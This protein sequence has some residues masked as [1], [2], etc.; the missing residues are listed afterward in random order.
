MDIEK[1]EWEVLNEMIEDGSIIRVYIYH[2][3]FYTHMFRRK[4]VTG[5]SIVQYIVY[6]NYN[7]VLLFSFI[8]NTIF[9][10]SFKTEVRA[11]A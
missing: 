8:Y 1:N 3:F 6:Y 4:M 2:S 10:Y 5:V 11:F 9:I 7:T